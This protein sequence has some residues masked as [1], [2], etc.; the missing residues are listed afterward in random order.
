MIS[1]MKICF[2]LRI[3]H[4]KFKEFREN[5]KCSGGPARDRMIDG[6]ADQRYGLL[7]QPHQGAD[8]PVQTETL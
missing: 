8:A 2:Q 3:S 6:T 1:H 5:I 7:L 4:L